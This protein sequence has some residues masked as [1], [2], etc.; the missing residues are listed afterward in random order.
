MRKV[1]FLLSPEAESS[2]QDIVAATDFSDCSVQGVLLQG[3]HGSECVFQFPCH[4][5][6][7]SEDEGYSSSVQ[8]PEML[9]M[10]FEADTII[11]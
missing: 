5:L 9:K 11:S 3:S 1:L 10:I 4:T 8:Y 2:L 7:S 6:N